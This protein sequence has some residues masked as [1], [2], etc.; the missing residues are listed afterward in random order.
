MIMHRCAIIGV[1]DNG[2][3]GITPQALKTLSQADM[4]IGGTRT[5]ALFT[6]ALKPE[7]MTHDLTGNLSKVP[8]W[9]RTA[10]NDGLRCA[11]LATGDPLCH[12]IA[13]YLLSRLCVDSFDILPN[14]STLQLACA[15][16]SLPWQE[17]KICSVHTK[18]AGEWVEG[19][20]AEHGLYT[21]RRAIAQHERLAILTSPD[22]TPDRIARLLIAANL[23]EQF[24]MAVAAN[25]ETDDEDITRDIDITEMATRK[26][27][28]PNVVL[29]WRVTPT[30]KP[31]LFGLPDDNFQQR[32]PEKGLITKREVR[33]VSLARM[34]LRSNSIVWDI[35]AGS[36]SVGVEAAQLCPQ[37]HVYAIEK[38]AGD[39]ENALANRATFGLHN[40]SLLNAKAPDGLENWPDPDAV[41]VGG[42]GGELAALITLIL[43]RLK[44]GGCLVMNFV[45]FENIAVAI[46]TLKNT[47]AEWDVTQMQCS[48]SKPILDMQRLAAENPVWI[49]SAQKRVA[50]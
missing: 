22:N 46:E 39:C 20:G 9:I 16:L 23:H 15:R 30:A 43:Q 6:D 10:Q 31:V 33:A 14:V 47:D 25:L 35:G 24:Q 41:F 12:G 26:F 50:A 18:D 7:C 38:N 37:G 45:T 42:S 49:V 32:Y 21:L 17:I 44:P 28:D 1:L 2:C 36:G 3:D 19:S 8:E 34:Q 48:R 11:V 40:Y 27:P 5:L 4:V 13:A 29:L